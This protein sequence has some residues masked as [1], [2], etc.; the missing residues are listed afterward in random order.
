[1][2]PLERLE[3][4]LRKLSPE[5]LAELRAWLSMQDWTAAPGEEGTGK[6]VER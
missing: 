5:E 4:M 6:P 2:T 1:M 3:E